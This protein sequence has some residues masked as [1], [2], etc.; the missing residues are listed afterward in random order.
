MYR[1]EGILPEKI[2]RIRFVL[3]WFCEFG[4]IVIRHR[5]LHD[6]LIPSDQLRKSGGLTS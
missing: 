2:G 4:E 6:Q 5:D 1:Q 3:Q